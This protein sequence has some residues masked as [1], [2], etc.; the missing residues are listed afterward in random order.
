MNLRYLRPKQAARYLGLSRST[1]AKMRVYGTGPRYSKTGS[2]VLYAIEDLDH[3]VS[4]RARN[5]TSEHQQK[6]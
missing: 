5:S 2:V 3:F 1:L 6:Q 4:M